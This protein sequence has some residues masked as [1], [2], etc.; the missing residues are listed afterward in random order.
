VLVRKGA[1]PP[2]KTGAPLRPARRSGTINIA[3]GGSGGMSLEAIPLRNQNL[4]QINR[5]IVYTESPTH[6]ARTRQNT[7]KQ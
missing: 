1:L 3:T 7:P 2:R 6:P 4:P 5:R